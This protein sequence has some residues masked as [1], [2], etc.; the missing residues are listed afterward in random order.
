MNLEVGICGRSRSNNRD[1]RV[2]QWDPTTE[3]A[4][5]LADKI[6]EDRTWEKEWDAT[7]MSEAIP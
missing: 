5:G 7:I 6:E 4:A 2:K 1:L 3:N